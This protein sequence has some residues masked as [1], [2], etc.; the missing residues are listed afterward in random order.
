M[1]TIVIGGTGLL[2]SATRRLL[3][4]RAHE[5]TVVAR[6][7]V[8]SPVARAV[9]VST[10]SHA[11][12]VTLIDGHDHLVY[13]LGPDDRSTAPVRS[14]PFFT[15]ALVH[16]TA[17]VMAAAREAGVVSAVV[18]GSYFSAH[19]RS[20]PG[21]ARRHVYV[22]ARV[23]QAAA[24]VRAGGDSMRVCVLEIPYVFGTTS[25]VGPQWK[26]LLFEPL[27]RLPVVPLP[28]GSTTVATIATVAEAVA[29][30][31]ESGEHGARLPV[32]DDD[33]ALHEIA[34]VVTDTLGT[35]TWLPEFPAPLAEMCTRAGWAAL[36]LF[37]K[38][39]GLDLRWIV[40]DVLAADLLVDHATT[41]ATLGLERRDARAAI[42][43]SV[44]ACYPEL[45]R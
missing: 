8:S 12:L 36:P 44:L 35:R 21:L 25:G 42:R 24:A 29:A 11:E 40:R 14:A 7:A 27:R 33:L 5:V 31:L 23:E 20:H 32:G 28:R 30:L 43:A 10:L 37:G 41:R 9:D 34:R 15:E 45:S 13:A 4:T 38:G 2:G 39:M 18:L 26:G 1:R 3:L 16:R 22:R 17:R 6:S 19:A